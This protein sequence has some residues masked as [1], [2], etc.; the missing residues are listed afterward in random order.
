MQCNFTQVPRFDGDWV[1]GCGPSHIHTHR[2][3]LLLLYFHSTDNKSL[4]NQN[5]N[6]V[7]E[8]KCFYFFK[9]NSTSEQCM[10]FTWHIIIL[11]VIAIILLYS[12]WCNSL[13]CM[14][15]G[16]FYPVGYRCRLPHVDFQHKNKEFEYKIEIHGLDTGFKYGILRDL[17]EPNIV[18]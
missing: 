1:Y 10:A 13:K 18:L 16:E 3:I 8:V 12:H 4:I 7:H 15:F 6:Y 14:S 17:N 5:D 9:Y 2:C 11:F